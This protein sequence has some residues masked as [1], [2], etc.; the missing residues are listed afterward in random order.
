MSERNKDEKQKEL[1]C[2]EQQNAQIR[3]T[4][5]AL[6]DQNRLDHRIESC[7]IFSQLIRQRLFTWQNQLLILLR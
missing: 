1:D 2:Q 6:L 7:H 3:E 5:E 4:G